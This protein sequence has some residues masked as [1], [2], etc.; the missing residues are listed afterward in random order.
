MTHDDQGS[1]GQDARLGADERLEA[2]VLVIGAGLAGLVAAT[3]A[4][5][6]GARVLVLDQEGEQSLGGQAHWSFGGL[7][8]VGSPEQRRLGI[9]DSRELAWSDWL[10]TAGFDRPE[11]AW[12][13]RWAEAFV[14]FAAG[15]LR[16]WLRGMGHRIFPVVGWAERGDGRAGG[17][18]N[19]VPR[20]HL[21]WGTGPGLVEPF[22][23][24]AREAEAAGA[25]RFAFRHRVDELLVEGGAVVGARGSRL[26][27]DD[28]PRGVATNREELGGFEARAAAVIVASGGIGANLELVRRA[29]PERLGPAPERM[30]SGV[31]AH[32]DGR[33]LGIA[34]SAGA[35]IVNGDRMWHCTE[36]IRNWD[37]I[38]ASHGIRILPGPSALWLDADGRRFE[39]PNFPGFDTPGTLAAIRA[40]GHDYSW[41]VM[42]RTMAE[43][44]IALSGSE[45]NPDLTGR[46]WGKVLE[47]VR[48]GAPAPVQAFID[49]G[50]D[51]VEAATPRELAARM[52]AIADD[53]RPIDADALE[54]AIRER[55][56]QLGNPFGKDAQLAAIRGARRSLPDRL[57]RVAPSHRRTACSTRSTGRSSPSA[58][59]SS[60]GRRSAA[61][62]RISRAARSAPTARRCRGC[63]PRAGLGLRRGRHAR[64]P[65]ARGH[66]PR[67]LPPLRP[68]RRSLRGGGDRLIGTGSRV[69]S[70]REVN[71]G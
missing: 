7:F 41:F 21:T 38:W 17:H 25:L 3:E 4:A 8:L 12:P 58:S 55:D 49:W 35:R 52:S 28:A 51:F 1:E 67:R 13:R 60:R 11:D 45:Q 36:G 56:L 22:A 37:P 5:Q 70:R 63:G 59:A 68:R 14:D 69:C 34:E 19:S 31:P 43:K 53:D 44:E 18:G 15:E 40:R 9:R 64:L 16:P 65:G 46:D 32:V 29:W 54:Q 61:S 23:R 24:R 71:A 62:R 66:V 50:A 27:P 47:R 42:T 48:P 57:V 33:M 26:A 10:G 39:A 30:I 6:R 2:D 20:F